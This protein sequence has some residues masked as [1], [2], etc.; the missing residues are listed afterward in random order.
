MGKLLPF[1]SLLSI[2]ILLTLGLVNPDAPALWMAS[3]SPGFMILRVVLIAALLALL[4]THPPRNVYLRSLVGMLALGIAYWSL[5]ATYQN[6]M[7]ILDTFS[8]L[9]FSI[10]AGIV[11][12]EQGAQKVLA[13]PKPV[14]TKSVRKYK[15]STA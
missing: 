8:L 5:S 14:T 11:V 12:L 9:Q 3:T 6:K 1:L 15:A 2:G 4:F 10:S 13:P 7:L